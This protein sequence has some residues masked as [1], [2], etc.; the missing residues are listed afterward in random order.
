M[1]FQ[2]INTEDLSEAR[3]YRSTGKFRTMSGVDIAKL[4]YLNTLLPYLFSL[5]NTQSVFGKAYLEQ[6]ARYPTY[7]LFR[8]HATDLY[9]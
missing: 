7:S 4:A 1:D 2:L 8:T 9:I 6:T 3:L 5:D